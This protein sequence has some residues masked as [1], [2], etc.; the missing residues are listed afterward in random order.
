MTMVK[1]Y[2]LE[3]AAKISGKSTRTLRRQIDK[4]DNQTAE[5]V[6]KK[7]RISF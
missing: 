1:F 3:E 6:I 2:T 7:T 5:N 4:L